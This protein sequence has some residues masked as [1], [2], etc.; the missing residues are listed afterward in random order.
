M[1][2]RLLIELCRRQIRELINAKVISQNIPYLH[3]SLSSFPRN[4][5]DVAALDTHLLE[6]SEYNDRIKLYNQRLAQQWNSLPVP[7]VKYNGQ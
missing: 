2:K 5:I 3:F 7:D 4:I 6:Q 1:N